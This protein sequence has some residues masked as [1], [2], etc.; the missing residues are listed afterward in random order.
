MLE[1]P[2]ANLNKIGL[3]SGTL[4]GTNGRIRTACENIDIFGTDVDCTYDFTGVMFSIGAQHLTANEAPI[5]FEEG[6]FLCPEESFLS[7]LLETTA[8]RYVLA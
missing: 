5:N 7:G 2:L 3:D 8:N 6:E 1:L 4:I